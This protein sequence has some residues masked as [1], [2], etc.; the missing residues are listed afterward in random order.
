L[1]VLSQPFILTFTEAQTNM[2]PE[3]SRCLGNL[4]GRCSDLSQEEIETFSIAIEA[5][6]VGLAPAPL[7]PEHGLSLPASVLRAPKFLQV[8]HKKARKMSPELFV[9]DNNSESSAEVFQEL[10]KV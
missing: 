1:F 8:V 7:A 6:E 5:S 3:A 4:S 9:S 10:L 2:A